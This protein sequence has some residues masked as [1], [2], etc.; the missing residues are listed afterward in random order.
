MTSAKRRCALITGASRGIG[1]AI[2]RALAPTCDL[3][4]LARDQDALGHVCRA[5]AASA[6]GTV[7]AIVCDLTDASQRSALCAR[8]RSSSLDILVNN[9]GM[10]RSAT[11]AA[12]DDNLWEETMLLNVRV[13]FLLSQAAAVGM[14]KRGFGRMVHVASTA[15]LKGYRFTAAYS[16]SKG[17]LAAMTRAMAIELA[18]SGVTVNAVCPGFTETDLSAAA[19]ANIAR[20]TGASLE[21]ARTRLARLSPLRRLIAPDE[22]AFAVKWMC[23][24][25]SD[26][27]T[28]LT[29]PVD[30]GET[31]A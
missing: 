7:E 31:I 21:D 25:H 14:C 5:L 11:I 20:V 17:A 27:L 18:G 29:L 26:A 8:I 13:P 10:A 2:A 24:E 15:A 3:W 22:V 6:V 23:G 16:A 12:T 19:V 9:A 30:G 28:G 4:L 1:E